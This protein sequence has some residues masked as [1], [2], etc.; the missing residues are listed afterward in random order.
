MS[1]SRASPRPDRRTSLARER[2]GAANTRPQ[3]AVSMLQ[4]LHQPAPHDDAMPPGPLRAHAA[5]APA[6]PRRPP[7][8]RPDDAERIRSW[9]RAGQ[10]DAIAEASDE[11]PQ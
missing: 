4:P 10:L 2:D 8:P 6:G 9:Y 11:P 7:R 5:G 3:E 1:G